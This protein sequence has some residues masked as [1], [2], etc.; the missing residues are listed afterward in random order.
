M[1]VVGGNVEV[2][3]SIWNRYNYDATQ[4][5]KRFTSRYMQMG[6]VSE[7]CVQNPCR[8]REAVLNPRRQKAWLGGQGQLTR[9][10]Y[11]SGDVWFCSH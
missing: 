5:S 1:I 8:C 9:M 3:A 10:A 2:V 4:R 7:L 6:W 11:L